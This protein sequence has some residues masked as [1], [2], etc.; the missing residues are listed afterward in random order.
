MEESVPGDT[1]TPPQIR[2]GQYVSVRVPGS[3]GNVGPGFDTMGLAL[4]LYD[5]LTV[6]TGEGL[7]TVEVSV[8][9]EGAGKVPADDTHLIIQVMKKVWHWAGATACG[10]GL[11]ADNAIPHGRGLGS[12]AAAIVSGALAANALLPDEV[13]L[14]DD[15]LFQLCVDMEGH[16]D[17]VAPSLYGGLSVSWHAGSRFRTARIDVLRQIVP[18]VAI[19][20]T[21]LSTD[22]ARSLLPQSVSHLSAAANAGRT[23]LLVHAFTSDPSYLLEGTDDSL[24]QGYR[25]SAMPDSAMLINHMRA[26]GF[27]AVVSGAGPT[28]LVLAADGSEAQAA[29]DKL[30]DL[31]ADAGIENSW[32][33][34]NLKVAPE[35]AKVE[36]HQ[37]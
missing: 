11:R 27:A 16:P 9:G 6:T 5:T 7:G 8:T 15:T 29:Q 23:A 20:D 31:L 35:G 2:A 28:V 4:G 18:V 21:P 10:L 37:R 32:R 19:P 24:H 30:A 1:T 17:N 3:S 25:A 14:D 26:A 33:V 13:R 12:S 36:V 34:L 22:A